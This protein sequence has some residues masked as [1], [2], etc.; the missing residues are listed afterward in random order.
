LVFKI[1]LLKKYF[2]SQPRLGPKPFSSETSDISFDKVFS[3]PAVPKEVKVK[4]EEQEEEVELPTD[5]FDAKEKEDE[6]E[7]IENVIEEQEKV[8]DIAN[9]SREDEQRK[10]IAD[11]RRLYENR[12]QSE[13]VEKKTSPIVVRR[14]ESLKEKENGSIANGKKNHSNG[15]SN[16]SKRTSTVF[17][18]V[19]KFRHLKGTPGHKSTHIENLRNISRQIPPEC[20]VFH[21]NF[22]R[23]AVP[24]SGAGGKIAIFE[25]SKPGRLPDGVIPCLVNGSNIMDFQWDPFDPSTLAVACDDGMIKL[26]KIP[27][28]GLTESTN[29]P[30]QEFPASSEKLYFIKFHPL[31]KDVLLTASYDLTLKLWDL[32]DL[33]EKI[34]LRGHTDQIYSFC[35]SPCGKFGATVCKDGKIRI[36][37]LRKS[38]NP[39]KEGIGAPVGTRGSRITYALD[40]EF[41]VVT[42]FDK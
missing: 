27:Q 11:R 41:L 25:L 1:S 13:A 2:F 14:Q 23:V 4:D 20:D 34:C 12:S 19:S 8:E 36:F 9:L 22:E 26:W 31:A 29:T 15:S 33:S 18:K 6:P 38:E 37:N 24:M 35:W 5:E 16:I 10:S 42:G 3:V 40:G 28:G 32:S 21:A 7:E 17:G 39:I 30:T